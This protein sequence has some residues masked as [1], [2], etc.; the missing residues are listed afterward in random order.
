MDKNSREVL[1][2]EP[3]AV[4]VHTMQDMI[5]A[6]APFDVDGRFKMTCLLF[7]QMCYKVNRTA[8]YPEVL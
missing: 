6:Y 5:E 8:P 4:S 1:L 7:E 2:K 3:I